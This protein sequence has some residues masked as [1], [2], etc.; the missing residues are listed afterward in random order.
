MRVRGYEYRSTIVCI[1]SYENS[2]LSGRFC[3]TFLSEPE[4]FSSLMQFLLKMEQMLDNMNFP[5]AFASIRTF[6]AAP[7]PMAKGPPDRETG[8]GK[9]STFEIRVLFRQ[10]ASWQGSLTWLEGEQEESFRS[11]L[12]L[13]MLIDS[14]LTAG[15]LNE[16]SA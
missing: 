10:N 4:P 14:A 13:S 16:D 11:V 3:N 5:G 1:D 12:E 2:I 9:L 15:Q 8:R 7:K 6:A